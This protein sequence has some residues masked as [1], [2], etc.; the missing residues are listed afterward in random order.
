MSRTYHR[1]PNRRELW[2]PRPFHR[3]HGAAMVDADKGGRKL[4][5][6]AERIANHREAY[7]LWRGALDPDV[8]SRSWIPMGGPNAN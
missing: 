4:V 1:G 5:T 8:A 7:A 6:Q 3:R 2:N